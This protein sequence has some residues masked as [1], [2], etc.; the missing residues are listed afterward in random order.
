MFMFSKDQPDDTNDLKEP[1]R[2]GHTGTRTARTIP[3]S[4]FDELARRRLGLT[5]MAALAVRIGGLPAAALLGSAGMAAL[6]YI[7]LIEP[8]MPVL[9]RVTL[10]LPQLPPELA[11][12]RIG[13]LSDLHLGVLHSAAN[14]RWA[15][16]QMLRE[17]PDLIVLTGDFVSL[18]CAIGELTP[19][20]RPL[21]APLG[22]YAILGNHDHWEGVDAIRSQLEP[23]GITF[24]VNANTRLRW[25]SREFWLAGVD[26]MWYG[27]PDLKA[28]LDHIP[29]D[30]FTILLAHEP[31]F[32]DIAAQRNVH[33]QLS[34]HTHGGHV[35]LP[36]LGTLCLPHH[37]L[38]YI[39]GLKRVESLQLYVA[40][41][42]GGLPVRLNCPPEATLLTL[43]CV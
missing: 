27:H 40:R 39:S 19:L 14:T 36:G 8:R 26:D 42:L 17:R 23:L 34:G 41:G 43:R 25:R 9:E 30:A 3:I 20:L 37:G 35:Q 28:A 4:L 13:Q 1:T 5:S 10:H 31:D 6:T 2:S 22:V 21:H 29:A 38:N 18:K 33:L 32:A 16:Q 12:L 15:V 7:T 11:G 24:L